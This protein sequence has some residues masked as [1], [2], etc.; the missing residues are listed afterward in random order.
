MEDTII[1]KLEAMEDNLS[2]KICAL[3][4]D[5]QML[6]DRVKLQDVEILKIKEE[7]AEQ[8][9]LAKELMTRLKAISDDPGKVIWK[10]SD[11]A[12][13]GFDKDTVYSIMD[14]LGIG[15]TDGLRILDKAHRLD[16]SSHPHYNRQKVVRRSSDRKVVRAVVIYKW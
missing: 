5:V 8:R 3:G 6:R 11:G 15:H 4:C 13:V 2:D 16:V 7:Q 12:R 9:N 10:S 14:S 1:K